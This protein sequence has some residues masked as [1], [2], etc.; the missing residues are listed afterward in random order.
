[1]NREPDQQ[2]GELALRTWAKVEGRLTHAGQPVPAAWIIL[3]PLRLPFTAS[4]DIPS[5]D[6]VKTDRAGRFIF[7][8]VPPVKSSVTSLMSKE[9]PISSDQSIPLDLR[10]G[11]RI[12]VDLGGAGALVTG[13]VVPS[14]DPALKLDLR[15]SRNHLV[16]REPGI[17]PPAGL[18]SLGFDPRRGW[19]RFWPNTDE[20]LAYLQT[21]NYH[22][23]SLDQD[24][25]F[26]ISGVPAGDYDFA[27]ALFEWPPLESCL[28]SPVGTK[29]VRVRITE[30]AARK[31]TFDLGDV[32]VPVRPRLRTGEVVPDL[33]F[34]AFS[35]ETVKLSELRGHYVLLDFWATWCGSCVAAMPAVR[36]LHETYGADK[37]LVILGLN[38]DDDPARA[39]QFVQDHPLPWTQGSLGGR[40]DDPDLARYAVSS[41][42]AYFLIGPDGKL[43]Q[44]GEIAE[45]VGETLRRLLP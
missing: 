4:L 5:D 15:R 34:T 8:R 19:N 21:R 12:E 24:G 43:I 41:V 16:R 14:G 25:R 10:P 27:I 28:V 40:A 45:E 11:Q 29:V 13:R 30:D 44:S 35:G 39:R 22:S 17:E 37:R 6:S 3:R 20:G 18:R 38:L 32:T 7:P 42:P 9:S 36:K 33:A 26:Q 23:A 2:A 1:M 31:G